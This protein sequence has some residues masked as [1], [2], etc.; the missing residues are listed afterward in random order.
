[1]DDH[2]WAYR[3]PPALVPVPVGEAES[4]LTGQRLVLW[5]PTGIWRYD[6][7]A[8]SEP[9]R[10]RGRCCVGV[11]ADAD[12]ARRQRDEQ[13]APVPVPV[14]LEWCW[15]EQRVDLDPGS[16]TEPSQE[17]VGATMGFARHLV[18]ETQRPPVRFHRPALDAPAVEPGM[19]AVQMTPAG[20]EWDLRICGVP[21]LEEFETTVDL[22]GGLDELDATPVGPKV[23]VCWESSWWEWIQT[24]RPPRASLPWLVP[25]WVE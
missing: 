13:P 1:M 9:H 2:E 23:P 18:A 4:A 6:V 25:V 17:R 11:L 8:A 19:R 16:V 24:G 15:V 7:I 20:P 14:P 3:R 10:Y 22:S 12:W 21:R 5:A